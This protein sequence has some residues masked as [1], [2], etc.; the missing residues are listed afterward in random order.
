MNENQIKGFVDDLSKI[1]VATEL[2]KARE[3]NF[4]TKALNEFGVMKE[5]KKQKEALQIL[6]SNKYE[7]FLYGGAAGGAKSWTGCVWI[8][9]MAIQYPETKYFIARNELK[10]ILE[11]VLVTWG[12]VA[13]TYGFTDWKYNAQKNFI[14]LGNGSHINF[15]ELKYKPSD[16]MFEDVGS[17]EYTCGWIEE[18][19]EIHHTGASVISSRVG[20][21]LNS[22]YGI[23]GIVLY[24]CNPKKN[25][26][27]TLFYDADKKGTLKPYR[28]YLQCL[29]TE[30]PFIERNY[31]EKM[32]RMAENDVGLY[33]RLFLGNWE[34]E[35]SPDA[36][37]DYEMVEQVFDNDH[38]GSPTDKTYLTAD[39]ARYGSDKAVIFIWKGWRAIDMRT[40]DISKT[41]EIDNAILIL[42]RKY[43]IPKNRCVADADGVGGGVVDGSGIIGFVNNSR[44]IREKGKEQNYANLKT[45]CMYKLADR[46]NAGN[47][48][49]DLDLSLDNKQIIFEELDQ[50]RSKNKDD[51]K[52]HCKGKDDI[53][54]DIGRSPDFLDAI[55]MRYFFDLKPDRKRGLGSRPRV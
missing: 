25:W 51:R 32:R 18:V 1:E 45:Q 7:E 50:I 22:K 3:F 16:P 41:T 47:I 48:W 19:G 11:S 33:Q 4:I 42:R 29:L 14:I 6:T 20:R 39:V 37:C 38:V 27:K 44:A 36:L 31:V 24:T 8:M 9:F 49:L 40:F 5:H 23:K 52:L 34:Y 17:T 21:H 10:D 54:T 2:W 12:K 35:D 53:K 26:A 43:G 55:F 46:I 28:K 13:K 15:I 30:N